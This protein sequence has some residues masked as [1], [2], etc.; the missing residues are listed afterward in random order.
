MKRASSASRAS[1][2]LAACLACAGCA[3]IEPDVPPP[4][5]LHLTAAQFATSAP[6]EMRAPPAELMTTLPALAWTRVALPHAVP[7]ELVPRGEGKDLDR[8]ETFTMWYRFQVP[9]SQVGPELNAL[10]VPRW[11][12]L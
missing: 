2:L 5:T 4:G 8:L 11:H 12:A 7:R 3:Y 6:G 1:S 10:Y 9:A